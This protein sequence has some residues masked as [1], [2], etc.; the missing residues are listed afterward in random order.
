MTAR[1]MIYGANG[2]TGRLVAAR[3]REL[4][5][6][7]VPPPI[8]AGRD[9]AAL[10][11][12]GEELGLP[13]RAFPLTDPGS[14]RAHLAD[15]EAVLS[16]AGPFVHTSRALVAGCLRSGV[17]YLDITGEIPVFESIL[18][19]GDEARAAGVALLP[20]VGFDVVPSDCL[21]AKLAAALPEAVELEL[22]F[23]SVG[24]S[25][26]A[27]TLKTMVEGLPHLGA[28][29]RG[30]KI[31][32]VPAAWR[33]KSIELGCGRRRVV[34]IPWGD[35]STAFHSTGIPDV[36]VYTAMPPKTIRWLRRLR[37]LLPVLGVGAVK[38][39]IAEFVEARFSGPDERTRE[40]ARMYLWGRAADAAGEEVSLTMETPEGYTLTATASVECVRRLLAGEVEPGAWTPSKA[41][42]ADLIDG[43]PGVKIGE[44]ERRGT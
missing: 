26:S 3:A 38:K 41:F 23:T 10:A 22:A 44:I 24:G 42:G 32:P 37:F 14:L 36:R 31:V 39:R 25:W 43:L 34:T 18:R 7:V 8:L 4:G 40:E 29:R 11:A 2:Y 33:E 19:R 20:G 27:G 1:W 16:C 12:L 17:H 28:V 21:A 15:V 5:P 13:W 9:E 35:V 6:G 30:G